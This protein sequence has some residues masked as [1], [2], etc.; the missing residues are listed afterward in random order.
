[1]NMQE[2]V[3]KKRKNLPRV[4]KQSKS[5]KSTQSIKYETK[6]S[7]VLF[8]YYEAK[9]QLI[10]ITF[11][12]IIHLSLLLFF[13]VKV[14]VILLLFVT[15]INVS[16]TR[17]PRRNFF[18][19]RKFL[20]PSRTLSRDTS[21]NWKY[22]AERFVTDKTSGNF[23]LAKLSDAKSTLKDFE[24]SLKKSLVAS[25]QATKSALE[26]R[27]MHTEAQFNH[28]ESNLKPGLE[29][30]S[31]QA[32]SLVEAFFKQLKQV[33]VE[34]SKTTLK[35]VHDLLSKELDLITSQIAEDSM[36]DIRRLEHHNG[37]LTRLLDLTN[38]Q[39]LSFVTN[40]MKTLDI[41][42]NTLRDALVEK[43][44][45]VSL[46]KK[47]TVEFLL[48]NFQ[49]AKTNS[50]ALQDL[51]AIFSKRKAISQ[52]QLN[53]VLNRIS[54]EQSKVSDYIVQSLDLLME[55][56]N[57]IEEIVKDENKEEFVTKLGFKG[58]KTLDTN[59]DLDKE[60]ENEDES[61]NLVKKTPFHL[62]NYDPNFHLR[63]KEYDAENS[64]KRLKLAVEN[65]L[66]DLRPNFYLS[67]GYI[68]IK[69][70]PN[71]MREIQGL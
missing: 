45:T 60:M 40:E 27:K 29:R 54:S 31:K 10:K 5:L 56:T 14:L 33:S 17:E 68:C 2:I 69:L 52:D 4:R 47:L 37:T 15:L 70:S 3:E 44:K 7:W 22:A 23:D 67:E 48:L 34:N 25:F 38:S 58:I 46:D 13:K 19:R 63:Q 11:F 51:G 39:I 62:I 20:F 35:K 49:I 16:K 1:M 6:T 57:P 9:H 18:T 43:V 36:E 61:G 28:A 30:I 65:S 24:R 50:K 66:Q 26:L 8:D 42:L 12:Y 21:P 53:Q 32:W 59:L 41:N 64:V 55:E 71:A